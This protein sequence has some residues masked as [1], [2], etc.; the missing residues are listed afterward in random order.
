LINLAPKSARRGERR[1][2]AA[3]AAAAAHRPRAPACSRFPA[4][5]QRDCDGSDRSIDLRI[6]RLRRKIESNPEQPAFL[7]PVRGV[8]YMLALDQTLVG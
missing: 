3:A 4:T 8:G 7:R 5:S 2:H 1:G 6:T